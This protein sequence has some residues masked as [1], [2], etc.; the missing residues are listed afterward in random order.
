MAG[1]GLSTNEAWI[2]FVVAIIGYVILFTVLL[3]PGKEKAPLDSI[4]SWLPETQQMRARVIIGLAAL[5]GIIAYSWV[6]LVILELW[7]AAI[8]QNTLFLGA[9]YVVATGIAGAQ[10][11]SKISA[12]LD[13]MWSNPFKP[14]DVITLR[15]ESFGWSET[16]VVREFRLRDTV[17]TSENNDVVRVF[18]EDILKSTIINHSEA[19][20]RFH[21]VEIPMKPDVEDLSY[22]STM[23]EELIVGKWNSNREFSAQPKAGTHVVH[24]LSFDD[25]DTKWITENLTHL[26]HD[27]A[28]KPQVRYRMGPRGNIIAVI[29]VAVRNPRGGIL[30][31]SEL[32]KALSSGEHV[33]PIDVA[34]LTVSSTTPLSTQSQVT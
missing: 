31:E 27:E 32:L 18:N 20:F 23:I 15:H 3:R 10:Y 12:T 26:T 34:P 14:A 21:S 22:W 28:I 24:P 2:A 7:N 33:F 6:W 29:T 8:V 1:L 25:T 13:L 19:P 17:I 16:G 5:F 11:Y 9:I 30:F 4:L